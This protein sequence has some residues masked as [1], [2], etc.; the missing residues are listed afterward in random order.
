MG[1]NFKSIRVVYARGWVERRQAVVLCGRFILKQ[2][3][4]GV[5]PTE[6]VGRAWRNGVLS[7]QGR[8]DLH[9]LMI[10]RLEKRQLLSATIVTPV[11]Q[12]T[13]PENTPTSIDLAANISDPAFPGTIVQFITSAGTFE[14]ELNNAQTP[15]TVANFLNYVGNGI[16]N[17]SIIDTV[18]SNPAQTPPPFAIVRGGAF[19]ANGNAL[20]SLGTVPN[21][22]VPSNVRGTLAMDKPIG[23]PD[24]ATNAWFINESNNTGLDTTNGGYTVFGK[25]IS[26]QNVVDNI[27]LLPT[28][29][30]SSLNPVIGTN[31]PV[32]SQPAAG[33]ALT[34][35]NLVVVQNVSTVLAVV[36]SATSDNIQLVNPTVSGTQL[37]FNPAPG[38]S[39]FCHVTVQGVD[40]SGNIV[41]DKILVEVAPSAGRSL[42]VQLGG[43]QPRTVSF[44]DATGADRRHHPRRARVGG[45][46]FQRRLHAPA[47]PVSD[48]Q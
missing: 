42:N 41:T 15:K 40:Q 1:V 22:P 32:V 10:E 35:S 23:Q 3:N 30:A 34:S 4:F 6:S 14:A 33:A 43:G 45:R 44:K 5:R 11:P 12:Q 27:D 36:F 48:R 18:I 31:L 47:G 39:G 16:Y 9:R 8:S 29:D 13:V 46:P 19:D 28:V 2:E 38:R 26:G 21:E 24:G 25:I 7:A 20:P 17:N 37:T